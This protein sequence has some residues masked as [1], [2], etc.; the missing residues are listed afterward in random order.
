MRE[1]VARLEALGVKRILGVGQFPVWEFRAPKLVARRYREGSVPSGA[2]V[3]DS[4][5]RSAD[6]LK[7]RTFAS[8]Q[9]AAQWFAATGA[10]FLSPLSTLCN[11]TGCLLTV[12][13]S[14][15]PMARDEDHF[16]RSGSIWFVEQNAT[17][18]LDD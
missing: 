3:A 1:T 15:E 6:H 13:G 16:T 5:I 9:R 11:G 2:A 8:D 14:A 18:L 10:G 17:A 12:P 7:S 4:A